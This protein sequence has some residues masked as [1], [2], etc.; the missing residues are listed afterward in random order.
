MK[1]NEG[2]DIRTENHE[3]GVHWQEM[4]V[5]AAHSVFKERSVGHRLINVIRGETVDCTS[6]GDE[7]SNVSQHSP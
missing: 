6:D 1:L 7:P 4:R 3:D 2:K 5:V